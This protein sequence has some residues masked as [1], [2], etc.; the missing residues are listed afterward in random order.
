MATR[1]A[2]LVSSRC[3]GSDINALSMCQRMCEVP[4]FRYFLPPFG[5]LTVTA[6]LPRTSQLRLIDRNFQQLTAGDLNWADIMMT[7][8][9]LTR[10]SDTFEIIKFALAVGGPGVTWS[11][12]AY[13]HADFQA[14][15]AMRGHSVLELLRSPR[16]WL[17]WERSAY[18]RGVLRWAISNEH[19]S[20]S[21]S[22]RL[23]ADQSPSVGRIL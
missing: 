1:H 23:F 13:G 17:T 6:L 7:G 14:L 8:G 16:Y 22:R 10:H 4:G 11:P 5:V 18:L 19:L 9:M 2:L 15:G 3:I 12:S 20:L 21:T